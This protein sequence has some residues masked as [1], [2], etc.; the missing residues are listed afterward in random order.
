MTP[1]SALIL[2]YCLC[3]AAASGAVDVQASSSGSPNAAIDNPTLFDRLGSLLSPLI[4][5]GDAPGRQGLAQQ[6]S[7]FLWGEGSLEVVKTQALY[8]TRPAAFGPHIA[9]DEGLRGHL[10]PIS[11]FWHERVPA[12]KEDVASGSSSKDGV[13]PIFG[14]PIEGGPG[15][16]HNAQTTSDEED[17][18]WF[19][20]VG[21]EHK[22]SNEAVHYATAPSQVSQTT[23]ESRSASTGFKNSTAPP[24]DWI[25]LVSR[26]NCPFVSKIRLAQALGA[27]AVV[28]G[29]QSP[30][31]P[32]HRTPWG[33]EEP[34]D[35]GLPRLL[36]MFAQGDVSDI[37]IP[38]T[39]VSWRSFED[40]K[41]LYSDG[42]PTMGI[43]IVLSRDDALFEW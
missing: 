17:D 4:P 30:P 42:D 39:F 25:A 27:R 11:T 40:L 24:S 5:N 19:E 33:W 16:K 37:E 14:C 31:E 3:A 8:A 18:F 26:G 36:T 2:L 9:T 13:D 43:E 23:F 6:G 38:S 41:R 20:V 28:V 34:E 29:D 22:E 10:I 32:A 12:G 35:D 1:R 21:S 15:W 7:S